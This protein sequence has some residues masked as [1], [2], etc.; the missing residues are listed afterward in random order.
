M[1]EKAQA[2]DRVTDG[3]YW[4]PEIVHLHLTALEAGWLTAVLNAGKINDVRVN[5]RGPNG[6]IFP[7]TM[8]VAIG[9][10][11]RKAWENHD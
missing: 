5:L 6:E 11:V 10:K 9:D 3:D 2:V 7:S 1:D 8:C 4:L